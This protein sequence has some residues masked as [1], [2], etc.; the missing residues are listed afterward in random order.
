MF[1]PKKKSSTPPPMKG[2]MS[3][4][5]DATGDTGENDS[6]GGQLPP[7]DPTV[8]YEDGSQGPFRCDQ[9]EHFQAPGSCQK[10]SGPIDPAGCCNLFERGQA[11]GGENQQLGAAPMMSPLGG[12]MGG[13]G[14]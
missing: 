11:A 14:Y 6:E 10:V 12:Q 8:K 9:C 5:P 3:A 7:T 4:I 2:L 13:G 1:P